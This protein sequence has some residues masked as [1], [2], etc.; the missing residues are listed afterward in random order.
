L[1][2]DRWNEKRI[3]FDSKLVDRL[4]DFVVEEVLKDQDLFPNDPEEKGL[5]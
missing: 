5:D 2:I 1:S 4:E 3:G